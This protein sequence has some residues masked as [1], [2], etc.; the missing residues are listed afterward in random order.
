VSDGDGGDDDEAVVDLGEDFFAS[1]VLDLHAFHP[2]DVKELLGDFLDACRAR[3]LAEVRVIHG[4]GTGALRETVHALL[5]RDP[6]VASFRL[7]GEDAGGWG[8]TLVRLTL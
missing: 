5:G 4:K 8:A 2:R 1:G 7:A 6:R 3:G